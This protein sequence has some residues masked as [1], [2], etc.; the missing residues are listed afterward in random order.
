MNT[1]RSYTEEFK[2]DAVRLATERGNI[3]ATARDLDISSTALN[4]WVHE[5]EKDGDRA[6]PGNGNPIDKETA[7]LLQENRRLKEE[8]EIL[9]K[10]VAVGI[11]TWRNQ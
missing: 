1:R 7:K 11:F 2:R 4:R 3:T 8:N 6:F 10:A 5:L 9:K